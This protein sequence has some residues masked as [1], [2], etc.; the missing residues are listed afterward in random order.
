MKTRKVLFALLGLFFACCMTAQNQEELFVERLSD[1]EGYAIGTKDCSVG[2]I[3]LTIKSDIPSLIFESNMADFPPIKYDMQL[4]QYVF[5][6]PKQNFILTVSSPSHLSKD[7]LID[8]KSLVYAYKITSKAAT[9]KVYFKTNPDNA[10]VDFGLSGL[11]PQLTANPIQMN[12]GEYKV[13]IS[14]VGYL[15]IDTTVIVPSDG[16]TKM[17]NVNL[18]PTFAT[19]QLDVKTA[20]MTPFQMYPVIDIDSAHIYMSDMLDPSKIRSFDDAGNL[21][22]YKIYKGGFIPVP[23]GVYNVRINTPGFKTYSAVLQA[24]KGT[25]TPLTA[26]LEPITG[27]LTIVDK[28]GT[29]GATVFLDNEVIGTAPL[30]RHKVRI[31]THKLR[32][33]K[34]GFLTSEK[35]YKAIIA[36]DVEET[37]EVL[38]T[39]FKQFRIVS[40]PPAAEIFV[41]GEREGFTPAD[42]FLNEGKHEVTVKKSGFLEFKKTLV[43]SPTGNNLT[44]TIICTLSPNYPITVK[45]EEDHLKIVVKK[46]NEVIST[47]SYETPAELQLPY[48]NYQLQLLDANHKTRFKGKFRHDGSTKVDAPCYSMGTFTALVGDYFVTSPEAK[49]SD[50]YSTDASFYNLMATA[51]FGRF[52]LFP[53]LSTSLIKGAAFKLNDQ[54][55]G[56]P[57]GVQVEGTNNIPLY[58][59]YLFGLSGLFI[60]GEFRLGGSIVKNLDMDFVGTYAWYPELKAFLPMSHIDGA[61]MF[62]GLEFSTRISYFNVN[63]KLGQ[64]MFKGNYNFYANKDGESMTLPNQNE[65]DEKFWSRPFD[66]S[67]FVFTVGFTLGEKVSRGNNM[68]RLWQKPLVSS[69]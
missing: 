26:K 25:A 7:I 46:G 62:F 38:M 34:E 15:S 30:F 29:M 21:E 19:V 11:S 32:F 53:G 20:D 14:K 22:Y 9:G 31:G 12:A 13:R 48:G 16:S 45:S 10:L 64:E 24:P 39:V 23:P 47:G 17:L 50:S 58:D 41:N 65:T 6:H 44:D 49:T 33:E 52:T 35:E 8:G 59:D 3:V 28:G 2:D 36:E 67:N 69:Y 57:L 4:H 40:A 56:K 27:Y 51:H 68:L 42:I 55:K 61:E 66:L 5:C 54:W 37:V 18:T 1:G 60:N 63:F 43:I